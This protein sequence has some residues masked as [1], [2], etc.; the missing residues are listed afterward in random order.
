MFRSLV[1][2]VS[3]A[4]VLALAASA[5]PTA[6]RQYRQAHVSQSGPY[7]RYCLQGRIWG[8]PGSCMFATYEQCM[9]SASGT[10]AYCGLS[11]DYA[12][13]R[14]RTYRGAWQPQQ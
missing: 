11:P 12:F 2:T 3:A 10:N 1:T 4:A 6:A 14:E 7:D 13:A 9:A 8:Y 5:S